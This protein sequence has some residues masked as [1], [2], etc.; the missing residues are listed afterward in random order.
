MLRVLFASLLFAQGALAQE[1]VQPKTRVS[2][3]SDF[4]VNLTTPLHLLYLEQT[5]VRDELKLSKD[6]AQKFDAIHKGWTELGKEI[7]LEKGNSLDALTQ[8][9]STRKM[10]DAILTAAQMRRLDQIILRHR[11][12]EHGLPAV[13]TTVA[14][15]LKL[16]ADQQERFETLRRNRAEAVLEHLT[17]DERANVIHRNIHD[18]NVKFTESVD[19]LLTNDQQASLKELLGEPFAGE[20]RLRSPL[21]VAIDAD[22]ARSIYVGQLIDTYGLEP[23]ILKNDS[24]HKE[25]KMSDDQIRK[26]K[27]LNVTWWK[28]IENRP[29]GKSVADAIEAQYATVF[30]DLKL[31]LTADQR[32]RFDQIAMQYRKKVAGE[33]AALGHPAAASSRSFEQLQLIKQGQPI[34]KILSPAALEQFRKSL[35]DPFAGELNIKNPLKAPQSVQVLKPNVLAPLAETNRL[36]LAR[37]MLENARRY[38]LDEDQIARLK[39]ID[40]DLPKLRKFLHRELSQLPPSTDV[41]AARTMIPEVKAVE[42]FRKSIFEQCFHVLDK[43]QQSLYGAEI[44]AAKA[45]I[46]DY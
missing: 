33:A 7:D 12:K 36:T 16:S 30:Y 26:V 40:E 19:R 8:A 3:P 22:Q 9:N 14:R 5:A 43:R 2:A 46:I 25:L 10:L 13:L 44:R 11:E 1:V 18:I 23:E 32:Q 20:I 15:E 41:G 24:V 17:S 37:F 6:Q 28:E 4:H 38:R 42:Q 29:N 39:A 35:G 45:S 27:E 34:E 31:I 21:S